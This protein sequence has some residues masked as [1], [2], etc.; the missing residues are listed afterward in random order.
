[1][2]DPAKK[3][4]LYKNPR[5]Q[6]DAQLLERE[7]KLVEFYG[8]KNKRELRR[9]ETW[10]R[11][12]KKLARDLL[13]LPLETRKQRETELMNGLKKIGLV[14]EGSTIDDV[15]GLKIEE[16]LERRLQTYV[17]RKGFANTTKQARQF[18]VH[19]H[20]AIAGKKI[21]APSYIVPLT[22]VETIGWYRKPIKIEAQPKKDVKKEFEEIVKAQENEEQENFEKEGEM[23]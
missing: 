20:I 9:T 8:L 22:E 10:L 7:R 13:G 23:E 4:K 6:W 15:L 5:K 11:Q 16:V 14:K 1:M 3:R 18:I 17:Y 2:G 19:G 21:S 12:K